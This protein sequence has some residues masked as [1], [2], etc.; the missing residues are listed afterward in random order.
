M[1]PNQ[2]D[3]KIPFAN[4]LRGIAVLSVLIAHYI[5]VF[6]SIKGAYGG[7][8]ALPSRPYST[9]FDVLFII[10]DLN[11]GPLGVALFFLVSGFVIPFSVTS[12]Y[13]QK[14]WRISFFLARFFRLWPTY[15]VGLTITLLSL[16]IA[17]YI[18]KTELVTTLKMIVTQLSFFRDWIGL[19]QLD[20]IVWTL[21]IEAKFYLLA[22]LFASSIVFGRVYLFGFVVLLTFIGAYYKVNFPNSWNPPSN[23]LFAAKY[24]TYMIIGTAFNLHFRRVIS[25]WKTTTIVTVLYGTFALCSGREEIIN[26]LIAFALFC[27]CYYLKDKINGNRFLD[28]FADISYPLYALHAAF[29]YIGLRL[30]M[31]NGIP[32]LLAL[33]LQTI[34][35]VGIAFAVHKYVEAPT[36][37][38]GR[39]LSKKFLRF[40]GTGN[41]IQPI[42]IKK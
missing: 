6:G 27:A 5:G 35:T 30:M 39:N 3:G 22:C 19:V 2:N 9:F 25:F 36:H 21:E 18:T 33:A 14:G 41:P 31:G 37:Q 42:F 10:P 40:Y 12:L 29:G 16:Y 24:L 38:F 1:Q 28:F 7:F 15:F 11:Y 17:A 26:Y 32:P 23:F 20:G 13:G 8:S 4:I 34:T